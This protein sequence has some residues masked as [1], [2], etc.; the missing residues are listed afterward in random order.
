VQVP[1]IE[2][3]V[4]GLL[5]DGPLHG[6]E[7]LARFQARS[8]GSWL[9]I[10]R[11]S[12]YQTL[13]RLESQGLV[14]GRSQE[15]R[16][17]PDRRVYRIT[18]A[19]RRRLQEGLG[20]RFG[21]REPFETEAGTAFGFLHLLPPGEAK[22]ALEAREQA[23]RDH[24]A[25]IAGERDRSGAEPAPA[26]A[27]ADALLERQRMLADAELAWIRSSKARLLRARR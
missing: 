18:G 14:V 7:L 22:A 4:L 20:E 23:L 9:Q 19:G 26:R 12:V 1:T 11:A 15:G 5:H 3:V 27:V 13:R 24:L 21:R 2:V 10:G 8:M 6:Y 25:A 17:G 16:E